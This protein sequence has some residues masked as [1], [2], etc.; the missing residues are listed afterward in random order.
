MTD[1]TSVT[2]RQQEDF[3]FTIDFGPGIPSLHADE[4]PPLGGGTGPTPLHLLAA[5][6]GNCLSDSLIFALRKFQQD[7]HGLTTEVEATVGRNAEGRL[8]VTQIRVAVTLGT[9]ATQLQ[10]LDRVLGQFERFCTVAQSVGQGIPIEV[11]VADA[12]G[13]R[14]K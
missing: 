3:Q 4:S 10:H 8:R 6:V 2:L 13:V 7:A 9:A 11:S 5:A 1:T 12:A 14:L